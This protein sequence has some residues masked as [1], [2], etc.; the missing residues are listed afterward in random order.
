MGSKH[1]ETSI[2]IPTLNEEK[3]I[4]GILK[5]LSVQSY[6]DFEV[7]VVDSSINNH[8]V[9]I[10]ESFNVKI[11]KSSRGTSVQRNLGARIAQGKYLIFIDADIRLF[12]SNFLKKVNSRQQKY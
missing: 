10:A 3:Y 5:D 9:N 6:K 4:G 12:D 8:T 2:I 7:I 1:I 11:L